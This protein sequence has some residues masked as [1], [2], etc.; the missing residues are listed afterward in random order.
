[1]RINRQLN[2]VLKIEREDKSV[3]YVHSSPVGQE[4]FDTYFLPVTKT[5]GQI[6]ANG[7][8]FAGGPPAA[9]R[10]LRQVSQ[11]LGV[12]G[13]TDGAI[14]VEHGFIGEIR[15]LTNVI[16]PTE[17][18]WRTMPFDDAVK[19]G[20]IDRDD[21]QEVLSGLVF[22]TV[23]SLGHLRAQRKTFLEVGFH[24]WDAQITSSDATAF[25]N[26]LPTLTPPASSGVKAVA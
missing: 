22:F 18:G 17:K 15:R 12:W 3:L 14:G 11:E 23:V 25:R 13:D 24:Q 6:Y 7:L 2:L 1:M 10:L 4:V 21:E 16:L 9:A 8:G 5:F 19:A 20:E 26:S